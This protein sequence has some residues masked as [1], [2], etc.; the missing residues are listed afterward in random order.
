MRSRPA[1]TARAAVAT[2]VLAALAIAGT[3]PTATAAPAESWPL[4]VTEVVPNPTSWDH[5][6][7]FEVTN[8]TDTDLT[9]GA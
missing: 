6:E 5:F 2:G 9:I 3:V 4:V 7:Y 1:R 8:T